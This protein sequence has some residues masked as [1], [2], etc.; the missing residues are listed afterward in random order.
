MTKKKLINEKKIIYSFVNN[1]FLG[2]KYF[3]LYSTDDSINNNTNNIIGV[4][5]D[6]HLKSPRK[7]KLP[8]RKILNLFLP[9]DSGV[10]SWKDFKEYFIRAYYDFFKKSFGLE[11]LTSC[12][13]KTIVREDYVKVYSITHQFSYLF[14]LDEVLNWNFNDSE[15]SYILKYNNRNLPEKIKNYQNG[16]PIFNIGFD[17]K[18]KNYNKPL[19]INLLYVK[20]FFSVLELDIRYGD[21]IESIVLEFSVL[22]DQNRIKTLKNINKQTFKPRL[23]NVRDVK[24]SFS[25]KYLPL[26]MNEFTYGKKKEFHTFI[27]YRNFSTNSRTYVDEESNVIRKVTNISDTSF[28]KEIFDLSS[29]KLL[30][31]FIDN[32]IDETTFTRTRGELTLTIKEGTSETQSEVTRTNILKNLPPIK[33]T[34]KTPLNTFN[35]NIGTL[36][37]ETFKDELEQKIK[38]YAIGF[39][40]AGKNIMIEKPTIK[41]YYLDE[42]LTPD[43]IVIDCIN[44]M[45][46][47]KYNRAIFY[48]HNLGGYDVV[49]ILKILLEYNK[50]NNNYYKLKT[51]L[52][53]NRILKLVISVKKSCSI[54]IT[55]ADSLSL[56]PMKLDLL[57][58]AFTTK[59]NKPFFPY[60]FVTNKT[61][62]YIGKTPSIEF[63]NKPNSVMKI[64]DYKPLISDCW[65]LKKETL[66]YLESDLISLLQI[67]Y[68]FSDLILTKHGIQV[69]DNLTITSLGV[70]IFLNNH[71]DKPKIPL[72]NDKHMYNDL[73]KGYYGGL[74]E[75]Y[76]GY[77]ENLYYYDVNS[78]YP[79]SAL[80]DMP[81]CRCNYLED[82]SEKGLDL[83]KDNLFGFFYCKIKTTN[84]YLGYLPFRHN[85]MLTHPNGN[86]EGWYFSPLIKFAMEQGCDIKILKGYNFNRVK[87]VFKTYVEEIYNEKMNSTGARKL[88]AKLLLNSLL[89]R[90][91]MILEKR[92]TDLVD[93]EKYIEILSTREIYDS[94]WII[95]DKDVLLTYSNDLSSIICDQY[96]C[97]Y[98]EELNKKY[99]SSDVND[100]NIKKEMRNVSVVISAA[101]T[102]YSSIYMSKIKL[103]ILSLGGKIYYTDTD[104]IVTDIELP[105]N[106]IGENIG[107]LKLEHKIVRGYFITSKTY[108]LIVLDKKGNEKTVIKAKGVINSKLSEDDF[109]KLYN[110]HKIKAVKSDSHKNYEDGYATIG[111]K[112]DIELNPDVYRKRTK[113]IDPITNNWIDTKPLLIDFDSV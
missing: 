31:T 43:K 50:N 6:N 74:S 84:H 82:F 38:V 46:Q 9:I 57:D 61:L 97:G 49:F 99:N 35:K 104:S 39:A 52:K 27:T 11:C 16:E 103:L 79:Y 66:S 44:D 13:I 55:L 48:T 70:D 1:N 40:Y 47:P 92:I 102:S 64:E 101:V 58:K 67:L 96:G 78:L 51:S 105:K 73:K 12:I 90:F 17:Y 87:D 34:K 94:K 56:L 8:E 77:G 83:E 45:L 95:K 3:R 30:Q 2:L 15:Y 41:K 33:P 98:I 91:G 21:G 76:R 32:K 107:E 7:K 62:Y 59:Y 86:F 108:C 112:E 93:Y 110:N 26:T 22:P 71:L 23:V 100:I 14:K 75:V 72:I 42:G 20:Y 36:D 4:E 89:G 37:L 68:E 29:G 80:K 5:V 111:V 54:K 19:D 60:S 18:F 65:D 53:D 25:N 88:I 113:I 81:G 85:A 106:Y 109:I 63:Y 69:S 24:K 10:L 28:K